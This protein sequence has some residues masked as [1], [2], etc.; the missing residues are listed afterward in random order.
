M[1][2]ANHGGWRWRFGTKSV[3]F[4]SPS[5]L[6]GLFDSDLPKFR[7]VSALVRVRCGGHCHRS[8][9]GTAV[10]TGIWQLAHSH[11]SIHST[12]PA[13]HKLHP[14]SSSLHPLRIPAWSSPPC[15]RSRPLLAFTTPATTEVSQQPRL[16]RW[17]AAP[18]TRP[19]HEYRSSHRVPPS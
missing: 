9:S 12:H 8:A 10:R 18:R 4:Q 13:D 14:P 6:T 5:Y 7:A 15:T 11:H 19:R 17:A 1:K 3:G 2:K 16:E